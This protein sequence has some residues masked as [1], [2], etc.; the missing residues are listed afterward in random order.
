MIQPAICH[1]TVSFRFVL[2]VVIEMFPSF[3]LPLHC[4]IT[5]QWNGV[6]KPKPSS[7]RV[8]LS[9]YIR[10]V[11]YFRPIQIQ[12][13]IQIPVPGFVFALPFAAVAVAVTAAAYCAISI[14]IPPHPSLSL[15]KYLVIVLSLAI[16]RS[17]TKVRLFVGTMCVFYL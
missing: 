17:L 11:V 9:R 14:R 15:Y 16:P 6:N 12:I 10:L 3:H 2:T 1:S 5:L 8:G 4:T 7:S 13:Q